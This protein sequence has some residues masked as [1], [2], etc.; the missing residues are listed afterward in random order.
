MYCSLNKC[1]HKEIILCDNC[2]ELVR[3]PENEQDKMRLWIDKN[4]PNYLQL[5]YK[6]RNEARAIYEKIIIGS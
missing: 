4:Y 1:E 2:S 5:D 6:G 3:K